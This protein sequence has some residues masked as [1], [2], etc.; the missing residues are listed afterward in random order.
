MHRLLLPFGLVLGLLSADNHAAGTLYRCTG[1]Q[2]ET[3]YTSVRDGFTQCSVVSSYKPESAKPSTNKPEPEPGAA[4]LETAQPGSVVG[5]QS[6]SA[7]KPGRRQEP[8]VQFRSSPGQ[9]APQAPQ[10]LSGLGTPKV[11]RG[12]IYRYERDGVL[13]YTNVKPASTRDVTVL[14]SY[15][16]SCYACGVSPGMDWNQVGL[17]L[18]AYREEVAQAALEHGIDPALVRAIMHAESAFRPNVVSHKGAQGLMQ[19]MPA[20]AERFGVTDAFDPAQNI[21]GGAR[22]LAWLLKRFDGDVQLAAA[23][24]NAGEGAVDRF[25]GVPPYEETQRY[26]ERVGILHQRYRDL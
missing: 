11:T 12:A 17:N 1:S 4:Q 20:T 9:Q 25:S 24:Y 10:A 26:V 5:S 8:V 22:Y 13:H 18:D 15:I 14:F 21:S 7:G 3:A 23:G 2:G 16:Q 6:S 19:L